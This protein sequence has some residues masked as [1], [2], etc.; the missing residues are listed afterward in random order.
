M[1]LSRS[2]PA[3]V[4]GFVLPFGLAVG[5]L[6]AGATAA[7]GQTAIVAGE[8]PELVDRVVAVVGDS[9]IL[10]T[11]IQDEMNRQRAAGARFPTD[12]DSLRS[13]MRSV[14]DELID[15]Q[16]LLQ[17]ADADSLLTIPEEMVADS[18][19]NRIEAVKANFGSDEAFRQAL[20]ADGYTEDE[21]RA[22][23]RTQLYQ[24]MLQQAYLQRRVGGGRPVV[25][26]DAEM[27]R[28]FEQQRGLLGQLPER[29]TLVQIRLAP[30]P[31]DAAWAAAKETADSLYAVVTAPEADF[32]E[33]ARENSDDG[34]AEEGGDLGWF[35]RGR[36]VRE[37][38]EVA[39]DLPPGRIS[40]PVR[41]QFGWHVIKVDRTRPGEVKAR[42][43][44]VT[45]ERTPEDAERAR[46]KADSLRAEIEAGADPR[47]LAREHDDMTARRLLPTVLPAT[48]Q[49][50][51]TQLPPGYTLPILDTPEG[52]TTQ[53]FS[54]T[55]PQV[56]ELWT[57][58]HIEEIQPPGELT[59]EEARE[60]VRAFLERQKRVERLFEELRANAYVEIRF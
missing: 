38:E 43:I 2:V 39:F 20:R 59:Y 22:Q 27:R 54:T 21:Y 35:R 16:L 56:G 3:R 48:R 11:Q 57:I 47:E 28:T 12:P 24:G 40:E 34:S 30:E 17:D 42:H 41:S 36:M 32:A 23:V 13:V 26:T 6:G 37:F 14:L 5:L 25:V 58:V 10:L 9:V 4:T 46:Q 15:L 51:N 60:D 49:Q 55:Y 33:V 31:S 19:D 44:L 45:P 8:D 1:S 29:L 52:G 7:S 18:L 50:V 53:P